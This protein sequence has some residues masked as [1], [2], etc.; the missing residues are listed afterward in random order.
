MAGGHD[1]VSYLRAALAGDST[2]GA[3]FLR[4]ISGIVWTSCTILA[5]DGTDAHAAFADVLA[6][7]QADGFARL[8]SYSGR[9]RVETYVSVVVR[10]LLA[11][12]VLKLLHEDKERGWKAF[13]RF[14]SADL[15]RLV[16]RRL[17][18]PAYEDLQ[19]DAY[20]E[21]CTALVTDDYRRLRSYSGSGSFTGFVLRT[22]DRLLIDFVR[23]VAPRRRLP[24]AVT[25]LG[26]LEQ[27]VFRL[28]A[29]Q[30]IPADF[31]RVSAALAGVFSPAP[32]RPQL[33]EAIAAVR[34]F[35]QD[36]RDNGR[37]HGPAVSLSG[38]T[39]E[40]ADALIGAASAS[41]EELSIDHDER[42]Q[43]DGALATL[44][45]AA[46]QLSDAERIYLGIALSTAESLPARE[47]ATLMQRPVEEIYKLRQRVMK[48]LREAIANDPAVKNWRMSVITEGKEY[49]SSAP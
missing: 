24:A 42:K 46:A 2:A 40:A 35:A 31:D 25:R 17:S 7:L 23:L 5:G 32:T 41:A 6:A 19:Q 49:P 13:E 26:A 27:A 12:R 44:R 8:R 47:I 48:R 28:M 39:G 29:W 10:D 18:G 34:S 36:A 14:F 22:A 11:V 45:C 16:R 4:R 1:L 38:M 21:I 37:W 3:E 20:Q 9:G 30:G 33:T 43:L 15:Q